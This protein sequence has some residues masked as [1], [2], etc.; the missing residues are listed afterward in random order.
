MD[1][2]S[3]DLIERTLELINENEEQK[4]LLKVLTRLIV[5][6]LSEKTI[7]HL[8]EQLNTT[9]PYFL[10]LEDFGNDL[11]YWL[12]KGLSFG[13]IIGLIAKDLGNLC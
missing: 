2:K 11:N 3:K 7:E 10:T 1:Y 5:K 6:S 13:D 8:K 9:S 12:D 4:R